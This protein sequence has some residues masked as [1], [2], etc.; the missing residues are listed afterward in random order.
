MAY[1]SLFRWRVCEEID[2]LLGSSHSVENNSV[3][4]KSHAI[5]SVN[6]HYFKC[7]DIDLFL[8][9]NPKE[10][11]CIMHTVQACSS[12]DQHQMVF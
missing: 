8:Y 11:L 9:A 4:S 7:M 5:K 10:G 12:V 6:V 1:I 2:T 3:T